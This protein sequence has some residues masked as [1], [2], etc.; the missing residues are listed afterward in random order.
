MTVVNLTLHWPHA[1][2]GV[3]RLTYVANSIWT[4]LIILCGLPQLCLHNTS[5]VIVRHLVLSVFKPEQGRASFDGRAAVQA[6]NASLS[7]QLSDLQ[8]ISA[9]EKKLL[10]DKATAAE[11]TWQSRNK[12][13]LE[14]LLHKE[15]QVAELTISEQ[16]AARQAE[17]AA[18]LQVAQVEAAA[19]AR[20]QEAAARIAELS[21]KLQ[22]VESS[23]AGVYV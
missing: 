19:A 10:Q 8:A 18:A 16:A 20:Q 13:L 17:K 14:Q 5:V 6:S 15:R 23:A 3:P 12:E 9:R 1:R 11:Q 2:M 4:L 21:S 22:A 7:S